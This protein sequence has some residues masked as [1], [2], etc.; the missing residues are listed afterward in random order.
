M[1][2]LFLRLLQNIYT[3]IC[4]TLLVMG[5]LCL[6]GTAIPDLGEF[7]FEYFDKV[8]HFALFGML[9]FLWSFYFFKRQPGLSKAAIIIWVILCAILLG[10]CMEFVQFYFVPFRDFDPWD[11]VANS[12]GAIVTAMVF[13]RYYREQV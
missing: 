12:L 2:G 8:V 4:Y 9:A 3:P 6:P 1:L 5:L 13:V 7:S 11:I 10:I